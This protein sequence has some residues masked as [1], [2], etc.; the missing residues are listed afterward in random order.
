VGNLDISF[1][2]LGVAERF[3]ELIAHADL[4]NCSRF[5]VG[6]WA[7][8]EGR[9][10]LLWIFLALSVEGL[11]EG[12]VVWNV[13]RWELQLGLLLEGCVG[14]WDVGGE[15]VLDVLLV[16]LLDLRGERCEGREDEV[17]D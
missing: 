7:V 14:A 11:W 2:Q 3:G 4:L 8:R 10:L 16:V 1:Q 15:G 9:A 6:V 17:S 13:G 12:C 5:D